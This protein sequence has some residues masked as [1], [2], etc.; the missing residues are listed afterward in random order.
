MTARAF[1]AAACALAVVLAS[2][3]AR[4]HALLVRREPRAGSTVP[5]APAAMRLWFSERLEPAFSRLR[6][7][8]E[9]G[10]HAD[11]GD[12]TLDHDNRVRISASR[13]P[14]SPG[15]YTVTWRAVSVDTHVTEGDFTSRVAP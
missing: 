14:L 5:T 1:F 8:G 6:V 12:A 9:R 2:A 13:P 15:R 10:E 11:R 4:G 3:G 7:V